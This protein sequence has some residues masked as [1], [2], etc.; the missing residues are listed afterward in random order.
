[1]L[2][3][4]SGCKDSKP[5]CKPSCDNITCGSDGC[6]GFC[7]TCN[8]NEVCSADNKCISPDDSNVTCIDLSSKIT[9]LA[10]GDY[11]V[12]KHGNDG[13]DGKTRE[14]AFAT[15]QKGVNSLTAG[16][17]LVIGP[18]EYFESV[19]SGTFIDWEYGSQLGSPDVDTVIKADIPGTVLIKGDLPAPV[20]S[21]L[22]GYEFVYVADFGSD[23]DIQ[24]IYELDTFKVLPQRESISLLEYLPGAF[25][26]DKENGKIYISSTDFLPATQHKYS[27]S[28]VQDHGLAFYNATRVIVEGISVTGFNMGEAIFSWSDFTA[29]T[30]WGIFFTRSKDC[31]VRNCKTFYNAAGIGFTDGSTGNPAPWGDNLID[32]CESWA[33]ASPVATEDTGGITLHAP[34]SDEVRN[35]KS[36]LNGALGINIYAGDSSE[37]LR[38][39]S[40][41]SHNLSWGNTYADYKIKTGEEH[42]HSTEYSI[43]LGSFSHSTHPEHC[44]AGD[45]AEGAG[46]DTIILSDETDLNKNTEFADPQN[47]DFRL[48]STSRFI[49]SGSDRGPFPYKNNIFYVSTTGDDNNDGH[50][51]STSLR[52]LGRAAL[53]LKP[54]DTLYIEPGVYDENVVFTLEGT[55]DNPIHIRGRGDGVVNI[56]GQWQIFASSNAS[57]ERLIFSRLL[58]IDGSSD[59]TLENNYF[60]AENKGVLAANTTNLKIMHSVF[61]GFSHSAIELPCTYD[62]YLAGNIFNNSSSPA[63]VLTET[64]AVSYSNYNNYTNAETAWQVGV[65]VQS[66]EEIQQNQEPQAQIL[67]PSFDSSSTP[68]VL[69]NSLDFSYGG[70]YRRPIGTF[71]HSMPAESLRLVKPAYVHSISSTTANIQWVTTHPANVQISWGDTAEMTTNIEYTAQPFATY[72]FTGLTPNTTYYFRINSLTIYENLGILADTVTPDEPVLT[73]TTSAADLAPVTYYVSTSGSDEND[74]LTP[75]NSLRTIQ[76]AADLVNVGDTVLIAGGTY[77]EQVYIKAT[78]TENAPITFRNVPGEKVIHDGKYWIFSNAFILAQ[79]SHVHFDGMYFRNHADNNRW[80]ADFT[81]LKGGDFNIYKSSDIKISRSLF[82]TNDFQETSLTVRESERITVDNCVFLNHFNTLY[83]HYISDFLMKNS[84][85][86]RP[87]IFSFILYVLPDQEKAHF[88][89]TIF[90]DNFKMKADQNIELFYTGVADMVQTDCV[91]LLRPEHSPDWRFLLQNTTAADMPETLINPQFLDPKFA[92]IEDLIASGTSVEFPADGFI[93]ENVEMNFTSFFATNPAVTS[94]GIGLNPDAF[95]PDGIPD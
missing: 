25:F 9:P 78:G 14:T 35:S 60:L 71:K 91:Y 10:T 77:S 79:K 70:P 46:S 8:D 57:I 66:L 94:Q 41:L 7:S 58:R 30:V 59:I 47:F 75:A 33:N 90:T 51:I 87:W 18:G 72:S 5:T 43:G 32:S 67:I 24:V 17:T 74:G 56:T 39:P 64:D 11:F 48:Q 37:S 23:H 40:L 34:Y 62:T 63:V 73:F 89:N 42:N 76:K 85:I 3:A 29:Y 54:G 45:Y 88:N 4:I 69:T 13:N 92:A 36:Y 12:S 20:F 61:S 80:H 16:Q 26:F 6:G 82:H 28:V 1:T 68:P 93:D 22:E 52:T 27:L 19:K 44:L 65:S 38:H 81:P 49:K 21:K 53:E 86:V 95:G 31:I 84:V 83:L 50:S 15:I 55:M 2:L